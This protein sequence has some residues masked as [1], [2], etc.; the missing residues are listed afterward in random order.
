MCWTLLIACSAR[1]LLEGLCEPLIEEKVI[2]R[3]RLEERSVSVQNQSEEKYRLAYEIALKHRR[4]AVVMLDDAHHLNKVGP[5]RLLNQLDCIKTIAGQTH[6][7]HALCGTYE[8][9]TL[10]NL[11]GQIGRRS[12]DVHFSRYK[13]DAA[14]WE[15]FGS[16]VKTFQAYM[17][18][19]EKPD[20]LPHLEYLMEKSAGC[21]G[22]LKDWSER[23][24]VKVLRA[25][26]RTVDVKDFEETRYPDEI[27]ARIF[28]EIARGEENLR[29]GGDEY[30]QHLKTLRDSDKELSAKLPGGA[31]QQDRQRKGSK[32]N[33]PGQRNPS[34][35]PTYDPA[36][37]PARA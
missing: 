3:A 20:L 27:L 22:L 24:L 28:M 21:V 25:G 15:G 23:A 8:L 6:V 18:V 31:S 11:S 33:L 19:H 37:S 34:R 29:N 10:R 7:P 17:P 12:I 5:A 9:L 4:P 2:P 30:Y 26:G 35:D 36:S 13:F 1:R 32:K 14:G 16:A